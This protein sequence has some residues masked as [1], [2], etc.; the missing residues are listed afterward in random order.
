[1]ALLCS[2]R[3]EIDPGCLVNGGLKKK[4]CKV[5]MTGASSPRLVV[6]LDALPLP[7]DAPRCDYLLVSEGNSVHGWVLVLELK[8]GE[9]KADTVIK[10]LQAGACVAEKL[11]PPKEAKSLQ[12]RPIVVFDNCHKY[13]RDQL[14]R[15]KIK[16]HGYRESVGTMKC[17]GA[18]RAVL[19]VG[20]S[21]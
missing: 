20:S 16:F 21:F 19:E 9:L 14:M 8:C 10:Q 3:K 17:G 13:Q 12:F 2:I 1:M 15:R 18:L 11:V 7:A 6:D 4:G 5:K